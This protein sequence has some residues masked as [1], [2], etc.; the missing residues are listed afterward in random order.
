MLLLKTVQK[1]FPKLA[2]IEVFVQTE[3]AYVTIVAVEKR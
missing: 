3:C 1:L 2:F